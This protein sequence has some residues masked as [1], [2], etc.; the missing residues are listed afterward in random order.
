MRATV[1]TVLLVPLAV[2]TLSLFLALTAPA[3]HT[4]YGDSDGI[5]END[6][7]PEWDNFT[8]LPP[9]PPPTADFTRSPSE[10]VIPPGTTNFTQTAT[11]PEGPCAYRWHHDGTTFGIGP[12]ATFNYVCC[13]QVNA[14]MTVTDSI[15]RANTVVK[16]FSIEEPPPPRPPPPPPSTFLKP[17]AGTP[18]AW[19]DDL[20]VDPLPEWG[21]VVCARNDNASDRFANNLSEVKPGRIQHFRTGGPDGGAYR[22]FTAFDGDQMWGE[23]CAAGENWQ[24]TGPT[25]KYN[26]GEY[27]LTTGWVRIGPS[28]NY[29][30]GNWRQIIQT[31]QTQPYNEPG[32]SSM[33][34]LQLR[35]GVFLFQS[36]WIDLW[37]TPVTC[38]CWIPI[39]WEGYYTQN[40]SQGWWRIRVGSVTSPVFNGATLLRETNGTTIPSHLQVGMYHDAAL[41]TETL[42]VGRF[43]IYGN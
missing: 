17:P 33:F 1:R 18:V 37:S 39:S 16:S 29:T 12:T 41:P 9:L 6:P 26:E 25:V 15:G 30:A 5:S 36:R 14:S 11:C 3:A 8:T 20:A 10:A 7:H 2:A 24:P 34:E 40:A 31:K 38:R 28:I 42:D 13:G 22:A 4:K 35:S 21:G 27:H 23:R 19:T 43:T 32:P